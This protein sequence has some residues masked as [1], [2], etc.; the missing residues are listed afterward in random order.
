MRINKKYLIGG[1]LFFIILG[2]FLFIRF[3]EDSWIKDIKGVWIKHGS[4]SETPNYV[5]E[6]QEIISCS[7]N[8]YNQK[9]NEG[10]NF[11]SQCLGKCDDYAVDIVHIPRISADDE[12]ENQCSD[13]L[14][15]KVNH[16]IELDKDGNIIRIV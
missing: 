6:Q 15:R 7:L 13:Y 14:N 9:K 5:I 2:I 12:I 16:F 4:P 3:N 1:I 8:L 11:S 10:M